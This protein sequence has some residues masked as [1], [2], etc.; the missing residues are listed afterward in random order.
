MRNIGWS[1]KSADKAAG[2]ER[3]Y[4]EPRTSRGLSDRVFLDPSRRR[5]TRVLLS[6]GT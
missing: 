1:K 3:G 5:K 6:V 2:G 4:H